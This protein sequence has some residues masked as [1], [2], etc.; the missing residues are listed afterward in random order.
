VGWQ[1]GGAQCDVGSNQP[2][3]GQGDRAAQGWGGASQARV[4]RRWPRPP[5]EPRWWDETGVVA[6]AA[7]TRFEGPGRR[8]GAD[9]RGQRA[10]GG[11]RR[12]AGS[13]EPRRG[14]HARGEGVERPGG[15]LHVAAGRIGE[16]LGKPDGAAGRAARRMAC[17][18]GRCEKV[19]SEGRAL[20]AAMGPKPAGATEG[21][22]RRAGR[23]RLTQVRAVGG[24]RRGEV[25]G[26][27]GALEAGHEW[28]AQRRCRQCCRQAGSQGHAA[29]SG[30][31]RWVCVG[32][33]EPRECLR[34]GSPLSFS[35]CC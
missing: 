4:R 12:C 11:P 32:G 35:Q 15:L 28:W 3:V 31:A 5:R 22:P 16:T 2:W 18:R 9:G 19:T 34:A 25:L 24:L 10:P 21:G 33:G 30:H 14:L 17:G 6:N 26:R 7:E 20:P 29:G 27:F 13:L 23:R 8:T 1:H